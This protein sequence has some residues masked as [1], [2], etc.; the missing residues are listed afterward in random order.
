[1]TV[2]NFTDFHLTAGSYCFGAVH[3]L[4]Y[5]PATTTGNCFVYADKVMVIDL[6]PPSQID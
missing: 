3:R 5:T 6:G 1:M 2:I 4:R